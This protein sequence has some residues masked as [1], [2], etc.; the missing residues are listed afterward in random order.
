MY[1]NILAYYLI[2]NNLQL[3]CFEQLIVM[4]FHH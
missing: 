2:V 3:Y 1:I 4:S